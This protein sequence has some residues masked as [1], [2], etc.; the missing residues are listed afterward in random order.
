[1]SWASILKVDEEEKPKKTG[2]DFSPTGKPLKVMGPVTQ[3]QAR[4]MEP[5]PEMKEGKKRKPKTSRDAINKYALKVRDVLSKYTDSG[6]LTQDILSDIEQ[7]ASIFRNTQLP[8]IFHVFSAVGSENLDELKSSEDRDL[9]PIQRRLS[10]NYGGKEGYDV[11]EQIY[12]SFPEMRSKRMSPKLREELVRD[13]TTPRSGFPTI[14]KDMEMISDFSFDGKKGTDA[15]V[16]LKDYVEEVE[17]I[18]QDGE[19]SLPT[20]RIEDYRKKKDEIQRK[21]SQMKDKVAELLREIRPRNTLK[22]IEF[23]DDM[24]EKSVISGEARPRPVRVEGKDRQMKVPSELTELRDSARE[25]GFNIEPKE[26][27]MILM[28]SKAKIKLQE[29]K[30]ELSNEL[31]Q[32]EKD[33]KGTSDGEG[34]SLTQLREYGEV[35]VK[36]KKILSD[37][38]LTIE[39]NL[40]TLEAKLTE[41]EGEGMDVLRQNAEKYLPVLKNYI[42]F[43]EELDLYVDQDATEFMETLESLLSTRVIDFDLDAALREVKKDE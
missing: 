30:D 32:L 26:A 7:S 21:E 24:A 4:Q 8:N 34:F 9:K 15:L 27:S 11:I 39:N 1:M 42:S 29:A 31:K 43:A 22:F 18:V 38:T 25:Y 5:V 35:L 33:I 40:D 3:D 6:A 13:F 2:H 12:D 36:N 14:V 20:D 17:K 19:A 41:M 23:L 16:E 28:I 10:E 37:L